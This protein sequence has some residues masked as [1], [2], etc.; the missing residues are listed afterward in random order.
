M[1]GARNPPIAETW[2]R[3]VY[4][5]NNI[6]SAQHHYNIIQTN[7][8]ATKQKK[9][10][11]VESGGAAAVETNNGSS[12]SS[13]KQKCCGS[14]CRI[15]CSTLLILIIITAI[16][17]IAVYV[18]R[19]GIPGGKDEMHTSGTQGTCSEGFSNQDS[20][21]ILTLNTFMI[22]CVPGTNLKCQE[23]EARTER[24]K[25]I[26]EWFQDKDF[27]VVLLQEI[28]TNHEV[29]RDGMAASGFCHYVMT[30]KRAGSGL[31]VFSKY[32]ILEH[33]FKDWFDGIA[34]G[35]SLTPDPMN[36]ESWIADKGVL[37][38][39]VVKNNQPIHIFNMHANSDSV[40]D[41]H[42]VRV[43]QFEIVNKFIESKDIPNDEFVFIGGDMNEDKD[44]RL[45][46]CD[47]Q[48]NCEDQSYY[49]EML[50]TLSAGEAEV[51]TGETNPW[52]Y[53]SEENSLL[54]SLYEGEECSQH[55]YLLDYIFYSNKHKKPGE[56]SVCR[57]LNPLSE[58]GKDLSDHFPMDCVFDF[59]TTEPTLLDFI[60]S[61]IG[62]DG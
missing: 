42:D 33:S 50:T 43:K 45:L 57:V 49:N 18:T 10:A 48:A 7:M 22:Y 59:S 38:A 62:V 54:K 46:T 9:A 26:G 27:D 44:C 36:P 28:W 39:K 6:G 20:V 8:T 11:D 17:M 34:S 55:Q 14:P 41:Y 21:N 60:Q 25:S 12:R 47:R 16:V 15:F 61:L 3:L 24:A 40:G 2:R 37:H 35:G 56:S 32:P 31:A 29:I 52:T 30:E 5:H 4:I 1:L 13:M 19:T 23:A 53:N 51:D 58:D